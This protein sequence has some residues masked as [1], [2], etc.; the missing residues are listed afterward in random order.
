MEEV[1]NKSKRYYEKNKERLK[2][3]AREY[4]EKNRESNLEKRRI[5]YENNKDGKVKEYR[6]TYYEKNK[7]SLL[8]QAK[9]NYF[10]N[11]K[12]KIEKQK[13]YRKNNEEKYKEYRKE[14]YE[15]NKEELKL[16]Q[17]IK[18]YADK[19]LIYEP[20]KPLTPEEIKERNKEY[21]RKYRAKKQKLLN[22]KPIKQKPL[23]LPKP[24]PTYENR[25]RKKNVNELQLY[26]HTV[27]SQGKGIRTPQFDHLIITLVNN[28]ATK[29]YR[30]GDL[31]DDMINEG[32]Y[33]CLYNYNNFDRKKYNKAFPY[34]TEISKRAFAKVF[35]EIHN[36]NNMRIN[37]YTNI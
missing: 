23:S 36:N 6:K 24:K 13:I 30:S 4:Y 31:L 17:R 7:E 5:T 10:K 1:T 21:Q 34:F 27:I 14:Y 3:K 9:E 29:F 33:T 22:P 8:K 2:E 15:K 28:L 20:K 37:E 18:R 19:G 35:N 12:T 11:R 16:K 25:G 26:Y 32:I